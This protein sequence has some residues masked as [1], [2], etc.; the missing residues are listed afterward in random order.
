VRAAAILPVFVIVP[1]LELYS[2]AL[3]RYV[4]EPAEGQLTPPAIN[5]DPLLSNVALCRYR[6]VFKAIVAVE[7][8][9]VAEPVTELNEALIIA[10]PPAR[11]VANPVA[12][13]LVVVGF[14]EAHVTEPVISWMLPSE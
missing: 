3:F 12:L 7:T 8:V 10:F 1:E 14:D 11:A 13:T 6:L 5:T 9:I 4:H 2:S